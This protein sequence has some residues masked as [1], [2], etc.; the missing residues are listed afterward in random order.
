MGDELVAKV[1]TLTGRRVINYQ[2]QILFD[3]HIVMEIFFFEGGVTENG[4][5]D[6]A[7]IENG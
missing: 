2:S 6:S 1:E 7:A 4:D 3:P 5:G